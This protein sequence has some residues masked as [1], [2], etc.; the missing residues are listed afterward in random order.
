MLLHVACGHAPIVT[1]E[2]AAS[3][4]ALRRRLVRS[5]VQVLQLLLYWHEGHVSVH[6]VTQER[7]LPIAVGEGGN[8]HG[9]ALGSCFVLFLT[10]F[11]FQCANQ[12]DALLNGANWS[13]LVVD[14]HGLEAAGL[15]GVHAR[16]VS[17]RFVE[18]LALLAEGLLIGAA[19]HHVEISMPPVREF[20]VF[21][22]RGISCRH[23]LLIGHASLVHPLLDVLVGMLRDGSEI[24]HFMV[25]LGA[26]LGDS[27]EFVGRICI[28]NSVG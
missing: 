16:L 4:L 5:P 7:D 6:L 1:V 19:V 17:Y 21:L 3:I 13:D 14:F 24:L 20:E 28:L 25:G 11:I 27:G 18:I 8:V 10:L 26:D 9:H 12:V 2:R 22:C 23:S 15:A